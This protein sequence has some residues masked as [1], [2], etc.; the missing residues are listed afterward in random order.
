[1]TK[2]VYMFDETTGELLGAVEAY[3][4]PLEKGIFLEPNFSTSIKPPVLA[5]GE[6]AKFNGKAWL[7]IPPTPPVPEVV[8]PLTYQQLR[9]AEYPNITDYLD[10][11]VRSD[12]VQKQAYIDACLAVKAKYPKV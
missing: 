6:V 9:A 1:M 10:A 2:T 5:A 3:E 4:S 8:I 11:V 12:L 7:V